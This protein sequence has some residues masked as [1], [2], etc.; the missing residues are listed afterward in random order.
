MDPIRAQLIAER[1]DHLEQRLQRLKA[2]VQRAD[3]GEELKPKTSDLFHS[4]GDIEVK[5]DTIIGCS[6]QEGI[7]ERGRKP[8]PVIDEVHS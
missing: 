6:F 1:L 7:L 2:L 8:C 4:S 3:V 5:F